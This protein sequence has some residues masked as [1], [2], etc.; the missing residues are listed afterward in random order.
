MKQAKNAARII[1]YL[2]PVPDEAGVRQTRELY[3]A[4]LGKEIGGEEARE[5]LG[6]V[7]RFLYLLSTLDGEPARPD[8]LMVAERE[9]FLSAYV[10]PLAEMP[11]PETGAETFRA[12]AP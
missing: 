8:P 6:R 7:M 1:S 12:S 11:T 10:T 3:L 5:I 4:R 9:K 2:V